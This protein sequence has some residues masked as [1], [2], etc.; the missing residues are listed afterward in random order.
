MQVKH[1]YQKKIKNKCINCILVCVAS[2]NNLVNI[3]LTLCGPT[4]QNNDSAPGLGK[5]TF[6]PKIPVMGNFRG[7]DSLQL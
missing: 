4:I 3:W 2:Q 5:K 7:G 6:A 1:K